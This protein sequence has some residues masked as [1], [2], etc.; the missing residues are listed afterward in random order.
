MMIES[1]APADAA[2][3]FIVLRNEKRLADK[4]CEQLSTSDT[5]SKRISAEKRVK[6]CN[7]QLHSFSSLDYGQGRQMGHLGRTLRISAVRKQMGVRLGAR[8]HLSHF[9][10]I[11]S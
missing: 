8:G 9:H 6:D 1:P 3:T 4:D 7:L 5:R 2:L 10:N 11:V